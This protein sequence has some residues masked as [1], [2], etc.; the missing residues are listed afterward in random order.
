MDLIRLKIT[1]SAKYDTKFWAN[2]SFQSCIVE[3]YCNSQSS[4]TPGMIQGQWHCKTFSKNN[5]QPKRRFSNFC[6][7]F[8]TL[9][10]NMFCYSELEIPFQQNI[11]DF[12]KN[13]SVTLDIFHILRCSAV[14]LKE[15]CTNFF[16]FSEIK[17]SGMLFCYL[18]SSLVIKNSH[19]DSM[20]TR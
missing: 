4:T 7:L 12:W 14:V 19:T 3:K 11:L 20:F 2:I 8:Q 10:L 16:F 17:R 5:L 1:C 15:K 9:I 18:L 6:F 13:K